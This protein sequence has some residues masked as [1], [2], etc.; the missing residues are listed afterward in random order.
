MIKIPNT[1]IDRYIM[2]LAVSA[3]DV[4]FPFDTSLFYWRFGATRNPALVG[5][6]I[7]QIQ[8]GPGLKKY[9]QGYTGH[10]HR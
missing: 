5:A 1:T 4:P 10:S 9:L 8:F 7:R 3:L 2:D 6:V